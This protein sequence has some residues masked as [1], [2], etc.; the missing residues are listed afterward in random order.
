VFGNDKLQRRSHLE[1]R[2]ILA[3]EGTGHQWAN[4]VAV[5]P[6]VLYFEIRLQN[7]RPRL[8][9]WRRRRKGKIHFVVL[10]YNAGTTIER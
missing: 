5:F 3:A 9:Q 6:A 4:I 7:V 1:D 10:R 2:R 8:S